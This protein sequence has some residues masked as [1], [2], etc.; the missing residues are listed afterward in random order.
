[1]KFHFYNFAF[2]VLAIVLPFHV[3]SQDTTR[4]AGAEISSVDTVTSKPF[5][6]DL[7]RVSI[8][9]TRELILEDAADFLALV[10]SVSVIDFGSLGQF[11]PFSFRGANPPSARIFLDDLP[12]LEPV[13]GAVHVTNIPINV[14]DEIRFANPNAL[15]FISHPFSPRRPYSKVVFRA[16]DWEY[17]DIG[18]TVA[19][20]V[21]ERSQFFFSANRQELD[22]FEPTIAGHK[23][24]HV[25]AKL[26]HAL[27][28]KI[29]LNYT[30]LLNDNDVEIPAPLLPDLV[31]TISDAERRENRL[32][33]NFKVLLGE[34]F[35]ARLFFSN[36]EQRSFDDSLLFKNRDVTTGVKIEKRL[37]FGG[38]HF[39]FGGGARLDDLNSEQLGNRSDWLAH[40]LVEDDFSFAERWRLSLQLQFEKHQDY[41]AALLPALNLSY[42]FSNKNKLWLSAH[43]T[44]RYPTF[45][46]RFWPTPFFRGDPGLDVERSA[47]VELGAASRSI[48]KIHL[49]AALFTTR[50]DDW[51]GNAVQD[52]AAQQFGPMNSGA[53]TISGVDGKFRWTYSQFGE[54]GLTGSYW[55]VWEDD[56]I[57]SLLVPEYKLYVYVEGGRHLFQNFVWA[58]IRLMGRLFGTRAG[59]QYPTGSSLPTLRNLGTNAVLDGQL[60]FEFHSARLLLSMENIFNRTYELT[61][62]FFMPPQ[63][64][65]LAIEWE[66]WD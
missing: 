66:F 62:G 18:V 15:H 46:E 3:Y 17:T 39:C 63:T 49:A 56:P 35:A 60:S 25:F 52:V 10:P 9:Q 38:H 57:K 2:I 6:E 61:P 53:R 14:V 37:R 27:S 7:E 58:K 32:D 21:T 20:P 44:R 59:R 13:H 22:G 16:G 11:S 30:A 23:G 8:E 31:P 29:S 54:A 26:S 33:Q 12:L 51:I 48:S 4:V 45:A 64:F 50:A 28:S 41:S 1:L 55:H 19:L 65:R 42:Q 47:A 5:A 43:L 36:I 34:Q 24:V 40:G